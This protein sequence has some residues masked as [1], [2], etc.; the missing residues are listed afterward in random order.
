LDIER[1]VTGIVSTPEY[2]L[3]DDFGFFRGQMLS[4]NT[5]LP[6][7]MKIDLHSPGVDFREPIFFFEGRYDPYCRPSLVVEYTQTIEAPQKQVIW[8][9]KFRPFPLFRRAAEI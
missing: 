2:S 6:E 1:I 5:L 3:T 4:L 8:F 7:V 9:D